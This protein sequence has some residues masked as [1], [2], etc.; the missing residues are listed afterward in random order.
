[1]VHLDP[2]PSRTPINSM[3]NYVANEL[4]RKIASVKKFFILELKF[5]LSQKY[6]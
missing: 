6:F 3:M 1:M 4:I 5:Q 2:G